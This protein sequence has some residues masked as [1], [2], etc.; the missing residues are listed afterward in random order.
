[1]HLAAFS[2]A[3][4]S[5][6]LATLFAKGQENVT[7]TQVYIGAGVNGST[8]DNANPANDII[9]LGG[10]FSVFGNS[11]INPRS[12]QRMEAVALA[13]QKINEDAS[14]LPGVTLAFEIRAT[15]G[16]VNRA[17]EESLRYV[18]ARNLTSAS[19]NNRIVL[20]ISGVF[21]A[22]FSSVSTSVARLLRLFQIPQIS[23]ASTADVLSDKSVFEYF[24]RTVPPDSYQAQA[25]VDIVEYFNW[26]YVVAMHTNDVYGIGGIT[27]FI[28]EIEKRNTSQRCIATSSSIELPTDSTLENEFDSAVEQINQEWIGNAT[29]IVLFATRNTAIGLLNA[30][31]RR[32]E[33]DPDFATRNITW[34]G[35]DAWGDNIPT[36]LYET[37]QG[38]LS[39]TPQTFSNDEYE[40]HFL[41]LNPLTHTANPWF[42]EY[43]ELIFNCSISLRPGYEQCNLSNQAFSI[44]NTGLQSNI[45][46][47]AMDAV[48]AFARAIHTLQQEHCGGTPGLCS[49]ILD[50]RSGGIAIQG[51]LLLNYLRNVSF[52]PGFS[53]NLVSF[54]SNGDPEAP[55]YIVNNLQ[56]SSTGKF[57]F[58]TVGRWDGSHT[59]PLEINQGIQWSNNLAS[60]VPISICSQPCGDGEYPQSIAGQAECCWICRPCPRT[61]QVS[62]GLECRDCE[63]G[64]G[65]NDQRTDCVLNPVTFLTWSHGWSIVTLILTCIGIVATAAVAVIFIIYHK[66]QVIKASSRELSAVLLSGIMLCYLLPFFFVAKPAPWICA[67]RRFSVGF[68]FSLCYSALL[69][70]T[71][72]IHRIFNRNI[73]SLEAPPLIS[74]LSQLF[75]TLILVAIQVVIATIWLIVDQPSIAFVFGDFSTELKCGESTQI[76]L[77][78]SLGY[79]FLLLVV[80]TYFA[81]RTRNVPQNFNEAKFISFTMY[82]LCVLWLAFIPV[83]IAAATTLGVVY[84]TGSLTLVIIL[85]AS[86]TLAILFVPKLYFLFSMKHKDQTEQP[87]S[88]SAPYKNA[89][90][91][92]SRVS[93][94]NIH[95]TV[96]GGTTVQLDSSTQTD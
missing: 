4:L 83:Y 6:Y 7:T 82:T 60:K 29:V 41:S 27:A 86:V 13:I 35:S 46:T 11:G 78:I 51:K 36:D 67:I 57:T 87:E 44:E 30:V 77:F 64:Y 28:S 53:V 3:M 12:I 40:R 63:Q 81:I 25:L 15:R 49:D 90:T 69:V 76:G 16:Q 68:C 93:V 66:N 54:N 10:L 42:A 88:F 95:E 34:I 33:R 1:M 45:V 74:P 96:V 8:L 79:N 58:V 32:R 43:W 91:F 37:V 14:V 31:K 61:L 75:F 18:S 5:L 72:R 50:S 85:N 56:R 84:Q 24:L 59:T 47:P 23:Y 17:L 21:G 73:T 65:P 22:G 39:V 62:T 20:G 89:S 92:E 26:S 38:S 2:S 94:P 71:N 70:K 55:N 52:S 19:Q 48:Y 9:V 80:T